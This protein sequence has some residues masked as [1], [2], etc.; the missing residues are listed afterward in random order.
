MALIHLSDTAN[1]QR[2]LNGA[3]HRRE[4]GIPAGFSAP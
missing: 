2:L 4:G 3:I 1:L